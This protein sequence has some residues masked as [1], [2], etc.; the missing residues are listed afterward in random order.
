MSAFIGV[1]QTSEVA[2]TAATAKTVLQIVA[3]ANHRVKVLG[4][5]VFFDG[6]SVTAEPV[7]VTVSRQST[8]GT[9]SSL[10]PVK[11]DDSLAETLQTSAQHTATAEPT[12]SDALDVIEVHPQQGY[13]I[14]YPL[15]QEPIIGGG[16][17]LGIVCTAPAGVNV[18][19]KLIFEE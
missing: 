16:D 6:T 17:R 11:L 8:A 4:W 12:T 7:Q 14:R 13:E 3:P 9:M 5:G 15:G 1:A 18:R 2:L 19:A 10:T